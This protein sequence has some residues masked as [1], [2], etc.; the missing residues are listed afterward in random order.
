MKSKQEK[1][2]EKVNRNK[3]DETRKKIR[4]SIKIDFEAH[5]YT[6]VLHTGNVAGGEN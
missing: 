1:E 3:N 4:E 6:A 2:K 5:T